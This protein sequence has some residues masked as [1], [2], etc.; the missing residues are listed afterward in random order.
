MLVNLIVLF[1][2]VTTKEKSKSRSF[3]FKGS[4]DCTYFFLTVLGTYQE[5]FWKRFKNKI[6]SLFLIQEHIKQ[7]LG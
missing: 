2:L 1:K 7:L 5:N 6:H 4:I 3:E